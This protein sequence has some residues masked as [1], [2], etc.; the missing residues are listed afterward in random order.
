MMNASMRT[1]EGAILEFRGEHRFLSNFWTCRDLEW[2]GRR[3]RTSEHAYQAAK[4]DDREQQEQVRLAPTAGQAKRLGR[5]VVMRPSWEREKIVVME[6]ILTSKFAEPELR[7]KLLA[8]GE[9]ELVEGNTWGDVFWGVCRGRGR[10]ELGK[11]LMRVR[12]RI[13]REQSR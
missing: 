9:R 4:T 5:G 12:D 11:A 7:A 2:R 13:R 10:N 6:D 1:G 3:W 8:T